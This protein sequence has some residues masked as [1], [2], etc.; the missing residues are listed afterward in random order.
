MTS[1]HAVRLVA[2]REIRERWRARSFKVSLLISVLVVVGA[3]AG[4][5]AI[6][7]SHDPVRV[8]VVGLLSPTA[9]RGV[10]ELRAVVGR[11]ITTVDQPD[12]ATADAQVR[13]KHLSA[14]I[15]GGA[16]V[17]REQPQ[18][19]DTGATARLAGGL[20]AV[21]G[22][23]AAF[24]SVGLSDAQIGRLQ[25]ASP[26]PVRG[27]VPNRSA[28]NRQ[29]NTTI[30]GIILIYTFTSQYGS[31]VLNGV[32][33]EKSSRVVEILLATLKP[34]QLLVG[35]IIG[36]GTLAVFQGIVVAI[37]AFVAASA[38]GSN[39]L[40]GSAGLTV[41]EMAGWF[42]LGYA[43]YATLY[44]AAGAL[45]GRQEEVQNVAF[46]I[47]LPLL[48][49]YLAGFTSLFGD[50][51]SFTKVLSFLPPTAPISMPVRLAA[52]PVPAWQIALSI[53][54][55]VTGTVV[56]ARVGASVYNRAILRTGSRM[57]WRQ[58]LRSGEA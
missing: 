1:A 31:W 45:V 56:A 9:R 32:V 29:R 5:R 19:G 35:K 25:A 40:R 43:F 44:G 58:A 42:I 13:A 23:D 18:P 50:V 26:A 27:L 33:Q 7:S 6:G 14:F 8:G 47:G 38:T 57:T 48:V 52:G 11:P 41:V 28:R 36:I 49:A 15:A 20:A 24:R 21:V 34:V 2:A 55:V 4:P 12:V 10:T 17:V 37:A 16:I 30:V 22:Q 39:V 54:L 46:P 3:I 53:A 51:S